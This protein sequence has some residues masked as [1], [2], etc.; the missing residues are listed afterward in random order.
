ASSARVT[1]PTARIVCTTSRTRPAAPLIEIGASPTPNAYSM[2]NCPGS[3]AYATPCGG[4]AWIVNVLCVSRRACFT[5]QT[6]GRIASAGAC[7]RRTSVAIH[8][9]QLQARR[10]ETVDD[11]LREALH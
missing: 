8:V 9:E 11:D 3:N 10:L 6:A 7:S 2:L 1:S 4:A 5:C